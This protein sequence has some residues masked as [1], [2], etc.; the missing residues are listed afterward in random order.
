MPAVVVGRDPELAALREFV[1]GIPDGASMLVLEGEAG[2]G[3]TTL[4]SAAVEHAKGQ[5]MLVLQALPAESEIAL[6]FF[7]A[8]DLLDSVLAE[9]VAF[10]SSAVSARSCRARSSSKKSRARLPTHL[11]SVLP[12]SARCEALLR[13]VRSCSQWTTC[14]GS[15]QLR[16]LHWRHAGRRLRRARRRVARQ[17]LGAP[18]RCPRRAPATRALPRRR[19]RA[20]RSS[21]AAPG[22]P[23][24]PR[25]RAT[26]PLLEEVRQA[27]GTQPFY[28]SK[29]VRTL[30]RSGP[31]GG[32]G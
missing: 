29:L 14:S 7:G 27:S 21:C 5:G 24:P 16:L 11:G 15:M 17:A 28:A 4:W 20:T 23:R 31:L 12:S 3:K 25:C 6:S 32:G 1:A 9:A 18:E 19:G 26:R 30:A 2:M 22:G 13:S 10:A 8:G